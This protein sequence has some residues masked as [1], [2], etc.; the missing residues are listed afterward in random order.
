MNAL[1]ISTDGSKWTKTLEPKDLLAGK[2][3]GQGKPTSFSVAGNIA[4]RQSC[5]VKLL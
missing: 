1:N 3:S 2:Q 4:L 5:S